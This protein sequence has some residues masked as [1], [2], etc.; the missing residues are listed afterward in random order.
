M[1][2]A[3]GGTDGH[4]GSVV[5]RI[6]PATNSLAETIDISQ[7]QPADLWPADLWVDETGIWVLSSPID[8]SD[9]T[10]YRADPVTHDVTNHMAIPASWSQNVF[11]AS[12]WIYV[13]GNTDSSNGAP[14]ETLF[15]IDPVAM[16]IVDRSQPADGQS[17]FITPSADRLWF[18][19]HGLRALD[20][21]TGDQVVGSIDLPEAC[22]AGVAADG[23]G[24]AWIVNGQ[25][26]APRT[27]VW[28]VDRDGNVV[29]SSEGD[30]G[31]EADGLAIDY[32]AATSSLWIVHYQDTV[33][34]LGIRYVDEPSASPGRRLGIYEAM[35]RH[36][37][38][39]KQDPIYVSPELCSMLGEPV[40]E[41]CSD[42]LSRIEQLQL[43]SRLADLGG[44][45]FSDKGDSEELPR[46]LL[47]PIIEKESGGL[48]VEGGS[49]CGGL[50]GS[51]AMYIVAETD[52]GYEILGTDDSYGSWIA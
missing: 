1:W 3:A 4:P 2:V 47:G 28:H 30:L 10:L 39:R 18:F 36:L 16:T 52:S 37:A 19:D 5:Y 46:I 38:G 25:G 35:I 48:R 13:L 24:G 41:P 17:L 32:D 8:G 7:G 51:G 22:C 6:D 14:A 27:G 12:G 50:C 45:V 44:V 21:A 33:L 29:A 20:A 23:E 40:G 43:A 31:N 34:R 42:R 15:R 49:V 26:D 11:A 9:M